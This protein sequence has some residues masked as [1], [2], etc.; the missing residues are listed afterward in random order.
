MKKILTALAGVAA[1]I[2]IVGIIREIIWYQFK[3]PQIVGDTMQS[4]ETDLEELT[5]EWFETYTAKLEGWKVP[6]DYQI[7]G[8]RITS[9]ERLTDLVD[10]VTGIPL[11]YVQ[12]D[13]MIYPASDNEQ[14]V[15]NLELTDVGEA[16]VYQ[17]QMVLKWQSTGYDEWIIEEKLSPV[18]YQMQTPEFHEEIS[19]PQTEH[20]KMRQDVPMTYY[21]ENETLY[22]TYDSG[23]TFTEVPGGYEA[24]CATS[25]GTYNELLPENSYVITPEFTG[26]VG[27]TES[28]VLLYSTDAGKTWQES[29]IGHSGYSTN[30]SFSKADTQCYVTMAVDRSLG[31]DYYTTY[32]TADLQTWTQIT[33]PDIVWSNLTC[34]CWTGDGIG[35]YAKGESLY[36]TKDNGVTFEEVHIP[37]HGERV[38]ELGYNP[39][40]SAEKIYQEEGITYILMGQGDDGDYARDGKLVKA[41]YQ[42]QDGENFTFVEE[43]LDNTPEEAG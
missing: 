21:I 31:S 27:Y 2:V 17:G 3:P 22:V 41:L 9:T 13:Y 14:I 40:D 43:Q 19:Q 25:N 35:Y 16:Y 1:A 33:L 28:V 32:Y 7:R 42:S 20:Y 29:S 11:E 34:T 8:A 18:Q 6:Y 4:S 23:D 37:E 24:V 38:A 12:I 26:F 36:L 5:R 39:F 10:S 30:M 15:S